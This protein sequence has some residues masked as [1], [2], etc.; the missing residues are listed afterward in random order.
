[1]RSAR[2]SSLRPQSQRVGLARALS[3]LGFCSRSEAERLIAEGRVTL[4]GKVQ[5]NPEHPV[6]WNEASIC[7]DHQP[8]RA[9]KKIYAM[10]NKPRGL[11]TTASDEKGRPTVFECLR[12]A[13]LP[14]LS[15]VGRLDQASEGLLLFTNDSAWAERLTNPVHEIEKIYH[16]QI[17]RVPDE[18]LVRDLERGIEDEGEH[19][20][21]RR[22]RVLRT[23]TRN[24]WLEI[25]LTEGKHRQIRRLLAG[26]DIEVL[27]L[28]RVAIGPLELG[29][30]AKGQWRFLTPEE[31]RMLEKS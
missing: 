28:V 3:K 13:E 10:L 2:P 7:V 5:R 19:L 21:A 23:G 26:F 24:G 25:T 16:A 17:N 11:V 14:F 20:A 30:L 27:R 4:D 22:V 12:G 18:A 15:P 1:M 9:A 8:V 6:I 29:A 31:V